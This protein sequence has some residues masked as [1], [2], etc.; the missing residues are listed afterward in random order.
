MEGKIVRYPSRPRK[1]HG[2]KFVLWIFLC[3]I[4][5]GVCLCLGQTHAIREAR[6]ELLDLE[7]QRD[8][9]QEGNNLLREEERLLRDNEYLEIQARKKLGMVRPG[10]IIFFV[11][12]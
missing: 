12:D 3:C 10:E 6:S 1:K 7:N 4:L 5:T 8:A 11:G 2:R 9:L